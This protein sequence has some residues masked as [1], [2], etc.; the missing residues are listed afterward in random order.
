MPKGPFWS[1]YTTS[2]RAMAI[3]WYGSLQAIAEYLITSASSIHWPQW[4]SVKVTYHDLYLVYLTRALL[5]FRRGKLETHSLVDYLVRRVIQIGFFD[6][7]GLSQVQSGDTGSH[8]KI[9]R[10][11]DF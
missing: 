8:A 3:V 9:L 6:T 2:Q 10:Q 11:Y 7:C 1:R 5:R 4:S